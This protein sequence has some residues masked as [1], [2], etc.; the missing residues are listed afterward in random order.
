MLTVLDARPRNSQ[1]AGRRSPNYPRKGTR[2]LSLSTVTSRRQGAHSREKAEHDTLMVGTLDG[3]KNEWG[4]SKAQV[5]TNAILAISMPVS[6]TGAATSEKLLH[7][8]IS[9]LAGKPTDKLMPP[10]SFNVVNGGS[11]ADNHLAC[12]EFMSVPTGASSSVEAM[13]IGIE[14][15]HTLKSVIKKI[16]GQDACNVGDARGVAPSVQDNYEALDLLTESLEKPGT[17][18]KRATCRHQGGARLSPR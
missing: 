8:Y 1:V 3:S 4:W 13:I 11:H 9:K 7:S 14:I 10:P 2:K 12:Q 5:G 6:R 16:Y 18:G 15:H 17:H